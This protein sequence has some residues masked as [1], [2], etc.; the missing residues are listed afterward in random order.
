MEDVGGKNMSREHDGWIDVCAVWG[1]S[2]GDAEGGDWIGH[3]T[4]LRL[5]YVYIYMCVCV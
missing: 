3:G 5:Y 4:L 1:F 2:R